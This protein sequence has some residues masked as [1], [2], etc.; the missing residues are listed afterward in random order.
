MSAD[1]PELDV[2]GDDWPNRRDD[3]R[4]RLL[5][6]TSDERRAAVARLRA[7]RAAVEDLQPRWFA[8]VRERDAAVHEAVRVGL[9]RRSIARILGVAS[10]GNVTRMFQRE[11]R[12][13]GLLEDDTGH[14]PGD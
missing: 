11:Q 4:E 6:Y 9:P 1:T 7:A 12:R 3:W 13:R 2:V 10:A 5:A 8:A 14:E